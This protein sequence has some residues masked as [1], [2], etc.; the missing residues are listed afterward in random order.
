MCVVFS[1]KVYR[2]LLQHPRETQRE[3]TQIILERRAE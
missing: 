2:D 1:Y 3:A